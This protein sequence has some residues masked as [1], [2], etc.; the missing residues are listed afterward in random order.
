MLLLYPAY[1][2]GYFVKKDEDTRWPGKFDWKVTEGGP[3]GLRMGWFGSLES[4]Y[5]WMY[6]EMEWV[7]QDMNGL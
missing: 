5:K 4:A 1:R 3:Q 7:S 6:R 2:C